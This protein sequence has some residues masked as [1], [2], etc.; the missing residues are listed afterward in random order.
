MEV[1]SLM[2]VDLATALEEKLSVRSPMAG[3]IEETFATIASI[4]QMLSTLPP[5]T[6]GGTV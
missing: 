1:D 2:V 6:K 5:Q 4:A 3:L